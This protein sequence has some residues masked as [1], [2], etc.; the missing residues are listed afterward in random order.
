MKTIFLNASGENNF[1]KWSIAH[2]PNSN[3]DDQP[4]GA[5]PIVM[6]VP[7]LDEPINAVSGQPHRPWLAWLVP[8]GGIGTLRSDAVPP[9]RLARSAPVKGRA[10]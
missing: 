4:G 3:D 7:A 8:Q 10:R 1:K 6:A 2:P 5:T 9:S